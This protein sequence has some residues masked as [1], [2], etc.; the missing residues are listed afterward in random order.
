MNVQQGKK[1]ASDNQYNKKALKS[2]F[3]YV[4]S[5]IL[6]RGVSF[7]AT[8]VYT[9]I[10]PTAVFGSVRIFESWNLILVPIISLNLYNSV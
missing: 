3:W 9:R 4:F 7:F 10:L 6:V 2:G 8:P 1:E 5:E